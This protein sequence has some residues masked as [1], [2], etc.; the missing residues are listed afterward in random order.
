MFRMYASNSHS[1]TNL[2]L[3]LGIVR[4]PTLWGLMTSK[5]PCTHDIGWADVTPSCRPSRQPRVHAPGARSAEK[6]FRRET[7]RQAA[8]PLNCPALADPVWRD[9]HGASWMWETGRFVQ[10]ASTR[11]RTHASHKPFPHLY[12]S[13]SAG[14]VWL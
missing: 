1:Y 6:F 9:A 2:I 10:K 5:Y 12:F 14:N 8:G 13:V 11:V 4:E 3:A 7:V